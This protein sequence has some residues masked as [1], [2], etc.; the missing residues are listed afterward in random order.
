MT[1]GNRAEVSE[2][3]VDG[4]TTVNELV[5]L[6][7]RT[8]KA[9]AESDRCDLVDNTHVIVT[10][11]GDVRLSFVRLRPQNRDDDTV[12][13]ALALDPFFEPVP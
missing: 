11:A 4:Q 7:D 12:M 6:I 8:N 9:L 3:G 10:A 2:E 13:K 5:A 1:E